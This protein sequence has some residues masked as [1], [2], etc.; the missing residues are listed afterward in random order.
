MAIVDS[1]FINTYDERNS[2]AGNAGNHL[3]KT[4]KSACDDVHNGTGEG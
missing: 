2:A 3:S 4:N 1:S